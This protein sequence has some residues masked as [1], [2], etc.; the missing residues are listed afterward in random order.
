VINLPKKQSIIPPY[1]DGIGIEEEGSS[2]LYVGKI[3]RYSEGHY[4]I[5]DGNSKEVLKVEGKR[6]SFQKLCL[7]WQIWGEREDGRPETL[8]TLPGEKHPKRE[9]FG[10][11]DESKW[12]AGLNGDPEDPVKDVRLMH[13][14]DE[15]T[16]QSYTFS[17]NS[18]GGRMA[19]TDLKQSVASYRLQHPGTRPIIEL[20]QCS[21][22]LKNRGTR[23]RPDFPIIGWIDPPLTEA[24]Y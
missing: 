12:P 19:V 17:T 11:L 16:G 18:Y 10:R 3:V 7:L 22:K 14:I 1:D 21:M 6:F 5:G 15:D 23:M 4:R 2:G 20:S 24:P 9:T 8:L 13:I